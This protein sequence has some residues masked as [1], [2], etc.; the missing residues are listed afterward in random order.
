MSE[1]VNDGSL[2]QS[3]LRELLHYDPDTGQF[4]WASTAPRSCAGKLAG[5][6]DKRGYVFITIKRRRYFAHRLAWLYVY[7][8]WPNRGLDHINCAK[9][10]NRISNLR[11]A[12][13]SQQQANTKPRPGRQRKKGVTYIRGKWQAVIR[14]SYYLGLFE[15]EEEAHRVYASAAKTLFGEFARAS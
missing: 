11:L 2:T 9:T 10:D 7:G 1:P 4:Q 14:K 13:D 8:K 3:N 15:T 12:T 6:R 5:S